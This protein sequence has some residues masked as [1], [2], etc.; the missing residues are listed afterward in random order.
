MFVLGSVLKVFFFVVSVDSRFKFCVVGFVNLPSFLIRWKRG[1]G[2][3]AVVQSVE[4][5]IPGE[6]VPSS[7]PAVAARSLLVGS[8]SV[9]SDRLRKKSWFN[10]SVSCVT[11][12]KIVRLCPG[13]RPRYNLVVNENVKKQTNQQTK[14]PGILAVCY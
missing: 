3:G 13:A 5:A 1:V 11:A 8:V 4:R 14:Y 12:C 6:E 2:G 10:S 9:E 7:I